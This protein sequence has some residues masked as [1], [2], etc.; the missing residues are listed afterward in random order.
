MRLLTPTS[1]S[2][3]HRPHG[4]TLLEV[5]ISTL[6]V[7]CLVVT[8]LQ[9]V[10]NISRTWTATNQIVDGQA[11]AQD[12]MR[13]TLA[14]AY[15][16]PAYASP[17]TWGR[18]VGE[19]N[20]THFDDIDDYDDWTESPVADA[21]GTAIPG[22]SGWSRNVVVKKLGIWDFAPKS[23]SSSDTGLRSVTVTATSP[24]GKKTTLT[25][26]RT[27]KAGTQQ[28]LSANCTPV[29]WV[30]CTLQLGTNTPST[31]STALSNHAEDQ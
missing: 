13:E 15:S 9:S 27:D 22:Y 21:A 18:G 28:L 1:L 5:T 31:M 3:Q 24:T 29:S 12:L 23:D 10:G 7:G 2:R 20:R 4:L 14:V 25:V 8:S 30:S 6:I 16:D 26:Y 11:L 17:N 19:S